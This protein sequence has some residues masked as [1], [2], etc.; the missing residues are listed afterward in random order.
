MYNYRT[1]HI[2]T[3]KVNSSH[4]DQK[5]QYKT[6]TLWN[7]TCIQ[8]PDCIQGFTVLSVFQWVELVELVEFNVPLDT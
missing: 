7:A 1:S 4:S 8:D 3:Y 5:A 6:V 2:K